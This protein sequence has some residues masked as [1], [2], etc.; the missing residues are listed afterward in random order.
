MSVSRDFIDFSCSPQAPALIAAKPPRAVAEH[1]PKNSL[2]L[3]Y[4]A[5]APLPHESP[6]VRHGKSPV[7]AWRGLCN[8]RPAPHGRR[9]IRACAGGPPSERNGQYRHGE[10][11]EGAIAERQRFS[12]LLKMLRAGLV[13]VQ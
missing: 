2:L 12:A 13:T 8:C 5:V 7:A 1:L 6:C 10:R 9:L 3:P 11:T 4:L